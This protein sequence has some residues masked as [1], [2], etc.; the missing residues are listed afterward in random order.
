MTTPDVPSCAEMRLHGNIGPREPEPD[1]GPPR[2]FKDLPKA[3]RDRS[4][5]L[6]PNH[7]HE[8]A[9][10]LRDAIAVVEGLLADD[11]AVLGGDFYR[12]DGITYRGFEHA[13][14]ADRNPDESVDDYVNRSKDRARTEIAR[15]SAD[16]SMRVVLVCR[17]EV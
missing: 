7:V 3:L 17:Q 16:D 13:W 14:A 5:D 10:L 15:W 2:W 9:M 11:V 8:H 12:F 6:R 4:I 1:P